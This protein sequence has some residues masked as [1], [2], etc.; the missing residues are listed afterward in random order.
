M[1]WLKSY[2][3]NVRYEIDI[4]V[5]TMVDKFFE[6]IQFTPSTTAIIDTQR[7]VTY[8]QLGDEVLRL[9]NGLRS[10]GI[11]KGERVALMLHNS[12]SYVE[13][14]YACLVI[15]AVIVQNNPQYTKRELYYQLNNTKAETLIVEQSLIEQFED[16]F[17]KTTVKQVLLNGD[18]EDYLTI[19]RLIEKNEPLTDIPLLNSQDDVAVI[20]FTG[21]TTGVSKG[22]MLTHYN[23]YANVEQTHELIGVYTEENK[24]V[25][26]NVLPLF[27]VYGMTVAM[28]Y[29]IFLKSTLILQSKFNVEETLQL[30]HSNKV[31]MFPGTPTIYVAINHSEHVHAYDLKSIH[32]CMSGSAPLPV[33]VKN[34][35]EGLTGAKVVDAYGLSEAAPVVT[36]NPVNG[37]RKPGSIG[38]PLP[39]TVCKIVKFD[40]STVCEVGEPGELLVQGPQVMKG[41]WEMPAETANALK[42][43]WLYTGDV[44][45]MDEDGYIFL[46]SR[47]KDVIISSGFNVY[48]REVEEVIFNHPFVKEV[49][50]IGIPHEYRGETVKVFIVLKDGLTATE[51][52]IIWFC[53]GKLSKYKLPTS[54]EFREDL[55]KTTVGKILR[56]KLVEQEESKSSKIMDIK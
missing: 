4:P 10:L 39:N 32:T 55:P 44:A 21:G 53:E 37:V 40:D 45:Y 35:F 12:I 15:G 16:V 6:A 42:N 2:P 47:K 36:S 38:I 26:L 29:M 49:V 8:E 54:V 30:I 33:E 18:H 24:E 14:Y 22:V 1:Q 19:Q 28:N 13:T 17:E 9:A 50:A 51:Q 56:R 31:T 41:Y 5:T 48:P 3:D 20:Q 25:L 11:Q 52:E 43:G 23:I 34:Q 7:T 27:H 46:V